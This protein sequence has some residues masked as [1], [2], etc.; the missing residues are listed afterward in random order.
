MTNLTKT[1]YWDELAGG[2]CFP[3]LHLNYADRDTAR[4]FHPIMEAN[5]GGSVL[6]LGCG[7]SN[8]LPYFAKRYNMKISGLDYS[9]QRLKYAERNLTR[10]EIVSDLRCIDIMDKQKDWIGK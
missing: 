6:E 2:S 5:K 10:L 8:F 3:H 4:V 1:E 7:C 9:A